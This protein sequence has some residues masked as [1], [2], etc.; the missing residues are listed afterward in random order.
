MNDFVRVS[1]IIICSAF[2]NPALFMD[3]LSL[4]IQKIKMKTNSFI[5]FKPARDHRGNNNFLVEF[6]LLTIAF[7]NLFQVK[8]YTYKHNSNL[9]INLVIFT[10]YYYSNQHLLSQWF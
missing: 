2:C 3:S 8:I 4:L 5:C 1:V 7:C 9:T 6:I 10:V